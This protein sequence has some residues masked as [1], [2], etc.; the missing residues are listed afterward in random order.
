MSTS[1]QNFSMFDDFLRNSA[2]IYWTVYLD[3]VL[4]QEAILLFDLSDLDLD[5]SKYFNVPSLTQH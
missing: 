2:K 1:L 3:V 5:L 4:L